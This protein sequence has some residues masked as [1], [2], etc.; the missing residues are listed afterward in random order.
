MEAFV[1]IRVVLFDIGGTLLDFH[2]PES[3]AQLS[4]GINAAYEHLD[5]AGA[6]LPSLRR[7][8]AVLRRKALGA[9]LLARLRRREPDVMRLLRETHGRLGVTL[10]D[11]ALHAL[12]RVVYSPS[13]ALA[14]A[15]PRTRAALLEL[16]E[17]GYRLGII[18]NTVA[19]PPG[20]DEHLADEGLLDL[21]P[22]RIY[23]CVFGVAKPNPRIFAEALRVLNATPSESVYIG[24]KP[25]IDVAGAHRAGLRAIL[26]SR[27]GG[28][29]V[30]PQPDAVVG[31]I[32]ELLDVLPRTPA[33]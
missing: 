11:A 20:L 2:Q 1:K 32:H 9:L 28:D 16:R 30:R 7:Y 3:L 17:R 13:K 26:R 19:P 23:S 33:P 21:F 25:A 15:H 18:S 29:G 14:H 5:Q 24:D 4:D 22:T 31:E 8:S 6:K 12:G 27:A 10:D